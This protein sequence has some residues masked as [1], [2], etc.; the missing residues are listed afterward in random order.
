MYIIDEWLD[1]ISIAGNKLKQLGATNVA[2]SLQKLY[3]GLKNNRFA[4][5]NPILSSETLITFYELDA[6]HTLIESYGTGALAEADPNRN[7]L[8]SLYRKLNERQHKQYPK[9]PAEAVNQF[10]AEGVLNPAVQ[11]YDYIKPE[12][13]KLWDNNRDTLFVLHKTL[14]TDSYLDWIK[15]T[16]LA[17]QLRLAKKPGESVEK[18]MDKIKFYQKEYKD[19]VEWKIK[20]DSIKQREL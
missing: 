13:Y 4:H 10:V 1:S 16:I 3:D 6:L 5:S 15:G 9:L 18:D 17:Y 12:H 7:H 20:M 11:Q 2:N 8:V 14:G 19:V